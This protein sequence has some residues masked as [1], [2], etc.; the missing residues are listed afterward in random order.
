MSQMKDWLS[1]VTM[2]IWQAA[3]SAEIWIQMSYICTLSCKFGSMIMLL[4][5]NFIYAER[6]FH[7]AQIIV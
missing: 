3:V 4:N 1:N 6:E 7:C 2:S 5:C